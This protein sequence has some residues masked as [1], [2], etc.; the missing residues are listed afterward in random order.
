MFSTLHALF[1]GQYGELADTVDE[2]AERIRTLGF[3]APGSFSAF[4]KLTSL[5]EVSG[6][7]SALDMVQ[8]LLSD[9]EAVMAMV[10]DLLK[11]VNDTVSEGFLADRLGYHQ[12]TAWM[13]RSTL[14]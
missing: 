3:P 11:D 8:Q 2:I 10:G 12:K 5:K 7:P 14:A 13:L 9:H 1:E 4:A 6:V